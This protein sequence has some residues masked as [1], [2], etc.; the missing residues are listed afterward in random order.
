MRTVP[1][2]TT[3][4]TPENS[5]E[6]LFIL[7]SGRVR[8]YRLSEEGK[9]LTTAIIEAGTIFGEMAIS[10]AGYARQLCRVDGPLRAVPDEP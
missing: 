7:K 1:G 10:G 6:V 9:V 8:L 4:F 3:F 2:D 5:S